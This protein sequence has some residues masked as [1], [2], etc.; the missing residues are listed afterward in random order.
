MCPGVCFRASVLILPG[1]TALFISWWSYAGAAF[2]LSGL[3]RLVLTLFRSYRLAA[4]TGGGIRAFARWYCRILIG[5]GGK[6]PRPTDG[7]AGKERVRGDYLTPYV[8]G[9]IELMTYPVLFAAGLDLYVGAWLGLKA[10]AQYRH[11]SADRGAF[12]AFLVGNA[13]VL[14]F[15]YVFLLGYV[16]PADESQTSAAAPPILRPAPGV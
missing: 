16:G 11:W 9:G 13:L 8:L 15:A 10:A 6:P 1:D 14:M 5:L 12:A 7:E 2:L 4:E 3:V